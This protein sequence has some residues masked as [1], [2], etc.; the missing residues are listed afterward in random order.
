MHIDSGLGQDP[1]IAQLQAQIAQL[2][3]SIPA[4]APQTLPPSTPAPQTLPTSQSSPT[5]TDQSQST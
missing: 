1:R 2:Q 5:L 3:Q 4:P